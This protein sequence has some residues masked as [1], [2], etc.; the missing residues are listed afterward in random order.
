MCLGIPARITALTDHPHLVRADVFGAERQINVGLI[1][2][3]VQTGEW[4]LL[5]VGFAISKLDGAEVEAATA[6]LRMLGPEGEDLEALSVW[7]TGDTTEEVQQ[8]A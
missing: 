4:V 8:W 5:H 3:G 7:E 6:S 2:E 1:E